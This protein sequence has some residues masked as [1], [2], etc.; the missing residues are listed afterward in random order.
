MISRALPLEGAP[1][2]DPGPYQVASE[3]A[4]GSPGFHVYRPAALDAFPKKDTLPVMVWGNGGCAIN[5]TNFSGFL[6]TIASHGVLVVGTV[7]QEGAAQRQETTDD[8]RAAIDWAEKE[9]VRAG[10]PL[11]GKIAMDKVAVMGTSCGGFLS[12]TLGADPRVKTIGVFNSGV[13]TP[14]AGQAHH[15]AVRALAF[16]WLRIVFRLWKDHVPYDDARYTLAFQE[17]QA[18]A[19]V[20][21]RLKTVAGFV[22]LDGVSR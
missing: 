22:K 5:S 10:S 19:P 11:N 2:A 12:I 14:P 3:S 18:A 21:I 15:A 4:F 20:E 8:M 16:K 6:T 17:R 13:Q 7:P 9:N 1:K